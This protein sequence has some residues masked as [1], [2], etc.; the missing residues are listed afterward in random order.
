MAALFDKA[1]GNAL[2]TGKVMPPGSLQDEALLGTLARYRRSVAS[3]YSPVGSDELSTVFAS[4]GKGEVFMSEKLDGELWFLVVQGKEIC[5][6]NSR[7]R[8]IHGKL[9]L[10][11]EAQDA[12][13]AI[14]SSMAIFAGELYATS[15]NGKDR[16]RVADLAAVL[17]G[18][19]S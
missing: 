19:K 6:A 9:P 15:A 12:S 13:K 17:A 8:V 3:S 16:P 10:L 7:G 14:S 1:K 2:G 5:F 4:A 11:S 18:G